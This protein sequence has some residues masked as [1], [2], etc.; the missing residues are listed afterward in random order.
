METLQFSS[1]GLIYRLG[2][3]EIDNL[4]KD[5]KTQQSETTDFSNWCMPEQQVGYIKC[6]NYDF[7]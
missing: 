7:L 2:K 3:I 5:D 6:K 1:Y 4:E